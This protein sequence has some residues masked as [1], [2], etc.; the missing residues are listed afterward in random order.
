MS[1]QSLIVREK[2]HQLGPKPSAVGGHDAEETLVFR[3]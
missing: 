3:H 2:S 1:R